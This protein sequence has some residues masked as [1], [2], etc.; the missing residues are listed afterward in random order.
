MAQYNRETASKC[1]AA[2]LWQDATK[3]H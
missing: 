1:L 3:N 2:K